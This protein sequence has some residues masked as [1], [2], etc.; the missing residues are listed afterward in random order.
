MTITLDGL[1]RVEYNAE[2]HGVTF[3]SAVHIQH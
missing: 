3:A 2:I 1:R